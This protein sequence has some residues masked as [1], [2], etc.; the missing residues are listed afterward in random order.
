MQTN[1]T[2]DTDH[3]KALLKYDIN[4]LCIARTRICILIE[5]PHANPSPLFQHVFKLFATLRNVEQGVN[6]FPPYVGHS[7]IRVRGAYSRLATSGQGRLPTSYKGTAVGVKYGA[8]CP[9][10]SVSLVGFGFGF[11]W[12]VGRGRIIL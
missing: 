1:C 9:A 2:H 8:V 11:G 12:V 10:S 3:T 5:I 4:V 6:R 7:P